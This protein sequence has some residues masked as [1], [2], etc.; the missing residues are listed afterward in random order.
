[1]VSFYKINLLYSGVI[2]SHIIR[3]LPFLLTPIIVRGV[4]AYLRQPK[5][6]EYGKVY[7]PKF[8]GILG[9]VACA[10]LFIPAGITA[11]S[12][13]PLWVPI[14]SLLLSLFSAT[15]IIAFVNCRIS[16]DQDGFIHKNFFGI[17]RKFTY[18]QVT[19]IKED[20][21]QKFIYIGKKKLMVDEFSIGGDDF[22][23]FVKKKYRTM[24]D[25]KSLPKIY[26][27]KHDIFN[28][29]V[30]D[31]G[32]FLFAYALIGVI[33]IGL[34]IFAIYLTYAPNTPNN[35][36]QQ[37]ISFVSYENKGEKIV[38]TSADNKIYIIDFIDKQ[39]NTK[40]IQMLCNE[41]TVVTTYSIKVTPKYEESYHSLK[42][43]EYNDNYILSFE[44]TT[45][46]HRQE[47][48]RFIILAVVMCLAW[49]IFV[50]F[51]IIVGRNP[52]KFSKRVVR[53]FFKNGYVKY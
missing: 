42:A 22:I 5:Q 26:K 51:S 16:Y 15:L 7:M 37:S 21:R 44:E 50:V 10:L 48:T 29:N 35:T 25:G 31:A 53:L 52:K 45:R 12:D 13:E 47:Y 40:N 36:V 41:K 34:L 9:L 43:V 4:I 46:L 8:L 32:G 19:A 38:L 27:T 11:F 30:Q 49:G 1:M 33:C 23:K 24:H 17:K 2:M 3:I 18:D 20:A 28:G 14:L 6:A 39:F